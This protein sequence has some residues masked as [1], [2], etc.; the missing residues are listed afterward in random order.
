MGL[1]GKE[2]RIERPTPEPFPTPP[3]FSWKKNLGT[4]VLFASRVNFSID[5]VDGS[6]IVIF[7][8]NSRFFK[9]FCVYFNCRRISL[10]LISWGPHSR[11]ERERKICRRLFTSSIKRE[12][13]HFHAVVVHSDG[14]E[15]HKKVCCTCRDVVLLI[16]PIAF[17]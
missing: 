7:K 8:M 15:M 5:D 11:L 9:L 2:K 12:M 14:K 13:R 3:I 1:T 10:K 17:L 6:E 4:R 16:K